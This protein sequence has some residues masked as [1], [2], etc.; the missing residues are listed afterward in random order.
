[1]TDLYTA[2]SRKKGFWGSVDRFIHE[3]FGN[4]ES[5]LYRI[6]NDFIVLLILFSIVSILLDSVE[7]I[8]VRYKTFFDI[9]DWVVV[10]FFTLEYAANIY[11]AKR[12]KAYLFGVWGII[13][14]LAIIPT[15]LT[16]GIDLRA[17]KVLR[18]LRVLR[19][20]RM[21]RML[22]LLKLAKTATTQSAPEVA[23]KFSTLKMD[24][25]IYLIALSTVL[26]TFSTAEYYIERGVENTQFTSIP[27]AM[28]W[29]IVTIT[30]VGYG[31]MYPS[32]PLG[33]IVAGMAMLCGVALFGLLMNVIGKSM[34]SSLFGATDLEN[35]ETAAKEAEER[36]R[37]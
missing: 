33:K 20:L 9:S 26:V 23:T 1:M 15:F 27:A 21:M 25:Q 37:K 30:T 5:K 31:D 17:V 34:M 14:F 12:K 24:L 28:W 6:I 8:A 4:E 32:T 13:D 18:I 2:P 7:S 11:V 16:G 19:F 35:A 10:F 3:G 36:M 22:R 29:C